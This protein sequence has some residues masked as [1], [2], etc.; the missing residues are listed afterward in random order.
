MCQDASFYIE[1]IIV[2]IIVAAVTYWLF[3]KNDENIRRRQYS[4][5]GVA[6]MESLLEEVNNGIVIMNERKYIPLPVKSWDGMK[7]VSDEVLLRIIAVSKK[8]NPVG[9]PVRDIRI[10]CKNYFEHMSINWALAV[11]PISLATDDQLNEMIVEEHY[12]EAAEKVKA[13]LIQCKELLENNSKRI[14]P[15]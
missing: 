5:L 2:P 3:K 13:M 1:K 8:I 7:T 14:F 9:F 4:T 12:L 10:H 6:I 15:K 11:T